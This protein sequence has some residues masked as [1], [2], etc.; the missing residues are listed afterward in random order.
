MKL[1]ERMLDVML[2]PLLITDTSKLTRQRSNTVPSRLRPATTVK[3]STQQEPAIQRRLDLAKK[4]I[5]E[6]ES[7]IRDSKRLLQDIITENQ[8]VKQD[9]AR[10]EVRVKGLEVELELRDAKFKE[11]EE[12]VRKGIQETMEAVVRERDE[13]REIVSEIQRISGRVNGERAAGGHF[14]RN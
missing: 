3:T 12:K 2:E 6:L 7:W 13:A 4:R 14:S 1:N 9:R 5:L 8:R 10:L 11:S